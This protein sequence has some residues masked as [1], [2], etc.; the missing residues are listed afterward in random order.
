MKVA[1]SESRAHRSLPR[2]IH[3][4]TSVLFARAAIDQARVLRIILES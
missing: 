3:L 4:I 1:P 2:R